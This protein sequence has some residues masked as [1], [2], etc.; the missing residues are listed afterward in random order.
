MSS[1]EQRKAREVPSPPSQF[2]PYRPS[3]EIPS[4]DSGLLL[5]KRTGTAVTLTVLIQESG[6]A[7]F[8]L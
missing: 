1:G 8:K 7:G 4:S 2:M 6:D 5:I 3:F